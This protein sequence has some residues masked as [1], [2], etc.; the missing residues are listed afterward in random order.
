MTELM[1]KQPAVTGDHRRL[2]P[3][4][5][6]KDGHSASVQLSGGICNKASLVIKNRHELNETSVECKYESV[7]SRGKSRR[8][9]SR[10]DSSTNTCQPAG[11]PKLACLSLDVSYEGETEVFLKHGRSVRT[12]CPRARRPDYIRTAFSASSSHTVRSSVFAEELR[13]DPELLR[14]NRCP[15]TAQHAYSPLL[16]KI[17]CLFPSVQAWPDLHW[18]RHVQYRPSI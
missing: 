7:A 9:V 17:L 18:K 16:L 15:V 1:E 13:V 5:R 2:H 4:R 12:E 11:T 10:C 14:H 6:E 8:R 3:Q